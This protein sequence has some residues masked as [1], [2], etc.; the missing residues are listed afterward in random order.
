MKKSKI[1]YNPLLSIEE[2][3]TKCGVSISAIR[4]YIRTNGIDRR[5]D[6]QLVVF[7]AIKNLK[8][9]NPD[10]SNK[11]IASTLHISL[12]TVKKYVSME[13]FSSI[14]NSSK[15]S[16]FDISKRKFIIKSVSDNQNEILHNILYLYIKKDT[17][18]I[19]LTASICVFYRQIPK[20]KLLFDKFPQLAGVKPLTDAYQLKKNTFH[21]IMIDLPFIVQEGNSSSMVAQRFNSFN[22]IKELYET[23]EEMIKLSFGLLSKGGYLIMKTMDMCYANKQYWVSTFIQNKAN[24]IG[25]ELVDT[26]ILIARG[27]ILST[28]GK[29][30]RHARKFHSYFFVF[31]RK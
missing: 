2:N 14:S 4:W 11:E 16:Y 5:H 12:N 6:S 23:N 8:A 7:N 18:D 3:A 30:Q 13:S 17:F 10:I 19:D 1:I 27:K 22:S 28:F 9:A 26:F 29:Q 21:S 15:L 24:E 25:F 20:P 31:K